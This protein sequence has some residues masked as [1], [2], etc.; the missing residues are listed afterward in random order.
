MF[1]QAPMYHNTTKEMVSL[2]RDAA[3][4]LDQQNIAAVQDVI[5]YYRAVLPK[6]TDFAFFADSCRRAIADTEHEIAIARY[7]EDSPEAFAV[8]IDGQMR[9]GYCFSPEALTLLRQS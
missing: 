8:F 6:I 5:D 3:I 7:G 4:D 2:L 9:L 1:F